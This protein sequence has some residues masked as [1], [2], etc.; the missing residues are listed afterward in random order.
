MKMHIRAAKSNCS[1]RYLDDDVFDIW[2]LPKTHAVHFFFR[3][4]LDSHFPVSINFLSVFS[5][6]SLEEKNISMVFGGQIFV[7]PPKLKTHKSF[8]LVGP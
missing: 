3:H 5:L 1:F 7:Y 8:Y 2:N 6:F 4:S